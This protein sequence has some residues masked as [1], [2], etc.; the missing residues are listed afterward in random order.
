MQCGWRWRYGG[1]HFFGYGYGCGCGDHV[2]VLLHF[3]SSPSALFVLANIISKYV[4]FFGQ[5]INDKHTYLLTL[6]LGNRQCL[7]AV[8]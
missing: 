6:V 3:G 4:C 8:V 1:R 2:H 5:V 7:F